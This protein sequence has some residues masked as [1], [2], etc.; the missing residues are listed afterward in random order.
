MLHCGKECVACD[1]RLGQPVSGPY[2]GIQH[3][4][5]HTVDILITIF[6]GLGLFFTGVRLIG[7]H[8]RQMTGRRLR[9]MVTKAV[10]GSR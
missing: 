4:S 8:L 9:A 10:A 7:Q 3:F 5:I 1:H 2:G 6:A